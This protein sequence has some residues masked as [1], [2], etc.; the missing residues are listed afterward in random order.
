MQGD[1][2]A[3]WYYR[4]HHQEFSQKMPEQTPEK[5]LNPDTPP[6]HDTSHQTACSAASEDIP[7]ESDPITDQHDIRPIHGDITQQ[8]DSIDT[9]IT[10]NILNYKRRRFAEQYIIDFDPKLAAI[11]AGYEVSN[12]KAT[13]K[14]LLGNSVV[15]ALIDH[16]LQLQEL[17]RKIE[18]NQVVE[19]LA[20]E[21]QADIGHLYDK[22]N[23][24]KDVADWPIVFR[25]GLVNEIRTITRGGKGKA[26]VETVKFSDRFQRAVLLGKHFKLFSDRQEVEVF[27]NDDQKALEH[28]RRTF[29]D[30]EVWQLNELVYQDGFS[31]AEATRQIEQQR[32]DHVASTDGGE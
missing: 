32:A 17:D 22:Q 24:I 31:V 29:T 30:A 8:S 9:P 11:R 5:E 7:S 27:A 20:E 18:P 25:R 14:E 2:I 28:A 6:A 16:K 3:C 19:R 21:L 23:R 26:V 13:G 10:N 15:R 12:A 1:L 4:R